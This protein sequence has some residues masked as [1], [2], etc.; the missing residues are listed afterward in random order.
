MEIRRTRREELDIVMA[1]Y[2]HAQK[3]MAE[4]GNPNAQEWLEKQK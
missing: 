3:F 1:I 4:Q 2:H